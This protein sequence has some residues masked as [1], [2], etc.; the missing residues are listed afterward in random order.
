MDELLTVTEIA[1]AAKLSRSAVYRAIEDG[2][3]E[4][5]KVRGRIRVPREAYD[6]WLE[7]S[8]VRKV[9]REPMTFE[10]GIPSRTEP[11][12]DTFAAKLQA[13]RRR[14]A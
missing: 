2:E 14:A 11:P 12:S 10:R 3:L 6:A 1:G 8:R 13:M 5:H 4:A 7:R 9:R